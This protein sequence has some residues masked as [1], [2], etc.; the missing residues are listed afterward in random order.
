M[1]YSLSRQHEIV[2]KHMINPKY[3]EASDIFMRRANIRDGRSELII[4]P[5]KY[6]DR[7]GAA[8]EIIDL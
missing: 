3:R 5:L 1:T 7:D 4:N 2:L 8:N 6:R